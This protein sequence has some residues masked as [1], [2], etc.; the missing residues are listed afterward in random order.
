MSK[1]ECDFEVR[2]AVTTELNQSGKV[3]KNSGFTST[4]CEENQVDRIASAGPRL[5][6][7]TKCAKDDRAIPGRTQIVNSRGCV[8]CNS[9]VFLICIGMINTAE[10]LVLMQRKAISL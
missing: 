1:T 3:L 4:V 7:H 6:K 8:H 2:K 10:C 5:Q 9:K